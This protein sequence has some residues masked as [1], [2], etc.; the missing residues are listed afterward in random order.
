MNVGWRLAEEVAW[1]RPANSG[2]EWWTLM[3]IAQNARDETRQAIPG[4]DYLTARGKCSRRTVLRRLEA[5]RNAGVLTIAQ[6]PAPG[7][8][9]VYEIPILFPLST[10]GDTMLTPVSPVDN[11]GTGDTMLTPVQ[12]PTGDSGG[13]NGCQ[14]PAGQVTPC[15]SPHSS[16]TLVITPVTPEA[17]V[18]TGL[19][20]GARARAG[21]PGTRRGL[22]LREIAKWQSE[23]SRRL[24]LAAAPE[25]KTE[26]E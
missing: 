23:E 8:R 26:S 12:V 19:V 4:M 22:T 11:P 10:T 15:V 20:E 2:P 21:E 24:R 5:L 14:D 16:V 6:R 9:A 3:D 1:A 13:G 18:G 17:T 25:Q 7:A